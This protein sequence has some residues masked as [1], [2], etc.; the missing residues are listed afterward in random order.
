MFYPPYKGFEEI[1]SLIKKYIYIQQPSLSV[2]IKI[3]HMTDVKFCCHTN[4]GFFHDKYVF[5]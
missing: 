1:D 2:V 3:I 4:K 5:L